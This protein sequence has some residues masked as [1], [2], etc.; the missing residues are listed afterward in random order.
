MYLALQDLFLTPY[1]R[2]IM[3][4][5][6]L[7]DFVTSSDAVESAGL[8]D[9]TEQRSPVNGGSNATSGNYLSTSTSSSRRGRRRTFSAAAVIA[10]AAT[11]AGNTSPFCSRC[12]S[13]HGPPF[14]HSIGGS[15]ND[16][17]GRS[18]LSGTG[19]GASGSFLGQTISGQLEQ[20]FIQTLNKIC[21]T[22]ERNELRT[23]MQERKD[24]IR[25]E[26]QQ[27]CQ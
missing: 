13:H 16:I 9:V 26:W 1:L 27:V 18:R 10:N 22:I 23:E 2:R 14:N 4:N 12:S 17:G 3:P 11:T 25:L 7:Q 21:D 20:Q 24:A 15:M 8:Y 19:G 6:P 5:S